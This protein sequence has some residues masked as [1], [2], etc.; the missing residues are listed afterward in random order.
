[1][2]ITQSISGTGALRIGTEFLSRWFPDGNRD[3]YLPNPTWA[4]HVPI[5]MDARLQVKTYRYF[6]PKTNGLDFEGMK[7]DLAVS[8][9]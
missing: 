1:M 2:A 4:N 9:F 6:D 5:S 8:Y 7:A 3:I